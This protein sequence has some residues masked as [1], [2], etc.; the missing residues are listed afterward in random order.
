MELENDIKQMLKERLPSYMLP[1]KYQR[2]QKINVKSNG[3]IDRN[4]LD[5]TI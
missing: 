1:S 5:L 4:Q 2:V 3:K